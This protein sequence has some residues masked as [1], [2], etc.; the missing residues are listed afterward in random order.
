MTENNYTLRLCSVGNCTTA[1][2]CLGYCAKHYMQHKRGG[3]GGASGVC[4]VCGASLQGRMRNTI[5]CSNRCGLRS[6]K[7]IT[8][9]SI[10]AHLDKRLKT[11][12]VKAQQRQQK[13]AA[14]E[15]AQRI[16]SL[17]QQLK[18]AHLRLRAEK[19]CDVCGK[20][21]GKSRTRPKDVCSPTCRKKTEAALANK[22]RAKIVREHKKKDTAVESVSPMKVFK[23]ANWKCQWCGVDTPREKRGTYEDCAPE[24]DH[25][26]PLSRGGSHTYANVQCLCRKCNGRKGDKITPRHWKS[27]GISEC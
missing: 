23:Q 7:G 21:V 26:I 11:Q 13:K 22:L 2:K 10:K 16:A 27:R 4:K 12:Q 24:L 5:Y 17:N 20:A 3:I 14:K 15:E 9:A 8:L 25:I 18:E 6:F 19:P 1:V